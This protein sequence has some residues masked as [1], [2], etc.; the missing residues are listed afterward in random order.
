MILDDRAARKCAAVEG[1]GVRGIIGVA[2]AAKARGL[3]PAAEAV[4]DAIASVDGRN[5][6]GAQAVNME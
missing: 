4:C 3:I 6:I 5:H 2:L 1:I